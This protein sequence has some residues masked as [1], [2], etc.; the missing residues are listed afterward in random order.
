MTAECG[1]CG[2]RGNRTAPQRRATYRPAGLAGLAGLLGALNAGATPLAGGRLT[3]GSGPLPSRQPRHPRTRAVPHAGAAGSAGLFAAPQHRA[4]SPSPGAAHRRERPD[5]FPAAPA[6]PHTGHHPSPGLPGITGMVWRLK[7]RAHTP[8]GGGHRVGSGP[9][10]SRQ[11][12]HPRARVG[13]AASMRCARAP[14]PT[15]S[16]PPHA[17]TPVQRSLSCHGVQRQ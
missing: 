1:G 10:P 8:A 16:F 4:T 13:W 11:P 14:L 9:R 2:K 3:G 17:L 5:T 7:R 15:F 12:R 6:A